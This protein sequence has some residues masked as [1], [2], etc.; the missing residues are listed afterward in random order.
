MSDSVINEM[1]YIDFRVITIT[2]QKFNLSR[3]VKCITVYHT[4]SDSLSTHKTYPLSI[5]MNGTL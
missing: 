5:T 3:I 2:L 1:F 4:V